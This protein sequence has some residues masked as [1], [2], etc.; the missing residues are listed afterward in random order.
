YQMRVLVREAATGLIG[1]ANNYIEVP[2]LVANRLT[3]SSIFP[4]P[5]TNDPGQAGNASEQAA[6]FSQR[7]FK[8]GGTLN[9]MFVVYHAPAHDGKTDLE[10]QTRIL[11]SGRPVF[12][13]PLRP[14]QI[15]SGSTPPGR[16]ITGGALRV[17]DRLTPDEYTLEVTVA[18]KLGKKDKHVIAQQEIDFSVE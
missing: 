4:L 6:T 11:K 5:D 3:M 15:L 14:I 16:I 13:G 10:M 9:Y 1:T 8:R 18:D 7:R 2:D 17:G 12:T